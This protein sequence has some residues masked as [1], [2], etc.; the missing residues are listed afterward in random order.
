MVNQI[1][2]SQGH[3]C[4]D[5]NAFFKK[6]GRLLRKLILLS[7]RL[8]CL[9]LAL[10]LC[11]RNFTYTF[12]AEHNLA[13]AADTEPSSAQATDV[14]HFVRNFT[15]Y[16]GGADSTSE[17]DE[18]VEPDIHPELAYR[19]AH[20]IHSIDSPDKIR[21][22]AD[23]VKQTRLLQ[24]RLR[25]L[26]LSTPAD[27][28]YY[29]RIFQFARDYGV[30]VS[31]V[32]EKIAQLEPR[33]SWRYF[34]YRYLDHARF[35]S[36]PVV[37]TRS[38]NEAVFIETRWFPHAEFVVRAVIKNLGPNWMFTFVCSRENARLMKDIADSISKNIRVLT[39][40]RSFTSVNDYNDMLLSLDFW[41][42]LNGDKI[43][44]VQ[45]DSILFRPGIEMLL[46]YDYV[47]APWPPSITD[48]AS[49]I[50]NGGLSLRTRSIMTEI[51]KKC[52]PNAFSPSPNVREYMVQ[53]GL[54]RVPEDVFFA[55]S[56]ESLGVGKIPPREVASRFI[57]GIAPDRRSDVVGGHQ[58]WHA[59][60]GSEWL[61]F[62][63]DRLIRQLALPENTI[64]AANILKHR[65]GWKH[66]LKA[67]INYD[68]VVPPGD[69]KLTSFIK[70][71]AYEYVDV[72]EHLLVKDEL[73]RW[74]VLKPRIR[75]D[76]RLV[77]FM[78]GTPHGRFANDNY[79]LHYLWS[80]PE[81]RA[82]RSRIPTIFTFSNYFADH[83]RALVDGDVHMQ[84]S[85]VVT[86]HPISDGIATDFA[87][88]NILCRI[89]EKRLV[90]L[91]Q[92][93][94]YASTIYLVNTTTW[95]K[96]WLPS[97]I[98]SSEEAR[99]TAWRELQALGIELT[100]D[101]A[102]SVNITS[103]DSYAEYERFVASSVLLVHIRDGNANNAVLDAIA[104]STPV[105]INRHPSAVE[106]LG[107][108]YPLYF[109]E[110][111]EIQQ[112]IEDWS[113]VEHAARYLKAMDKTRFLMHA[114]VS[115]FHK[116]VEGIIHRAVG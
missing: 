78:H 7:F 102:S 103:I 106:Y 96:Y 70:R 57:E 59:M 55:R 10:G 28:V 73:E 100:E 23:L 75:N 116:N 31:Q 14:T 42:K 32:Y 63:H 33:M 30:D 25:V 110:V 107:P 9:A 52:D 37:A 50:G 34:C 94:R 5:R 43:L 4:V 93:N 11:K 2:R 97:S 26:G 104:T 13:I 111:I 27:M 3:M 39:L 83:V 15:L 47:G 22:N 114:F 108:D 101:V 67:L 60:Q 84:T 20:N 61:T 90:A 115:S 80:S 109:D 68:F 77:P 95:Q 35:W 54:K 12:L 56:M 58:F 24:H 19:L 45:E 113:R 36:L 51:L 8:F 1:E 41:E 16:I 82:V 89:C 91:G 112:I 17:M 49:G 81:F 48:V 53:A 71:P 46:T 85:V 66:V 6:E 65:G 92:Q 79:E 86:S 29:I 38:E 88:E 74:S 62:A 76:T 64:P 40:D 105:I 72:L 44:I 98:I 99:D 18:G 87:N 69:R 21:H